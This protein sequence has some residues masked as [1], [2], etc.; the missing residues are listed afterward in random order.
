MNAAVAPASTHVLAD[1]EARRLIRED[2]D[3]TLIV[4]AAMLLGGV[5]IYARVT[6]GRDGVGRVGL[7]VLVGFTL[8]MHFVG[9]LGPPP[10][11]EQIP[12]SAV[13]MALPLAA[14]HFVDRHRAEI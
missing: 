4:E 1:D 8:V 9:Y 11:V 2:L 6:R 12:F 13:F 3:S 5:A 10:P 14:A 7:W